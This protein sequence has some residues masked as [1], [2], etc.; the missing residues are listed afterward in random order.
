MNQPGLKT[1]F[2][3]W[4]LN[5]LAVLAASQIVSGITYDSW[6]SLLIASLVLGI[7]NAFLRPLLMLF[8]VV[9]LLLTLG[10]FTLVINALL[11]YLVSWLV[12]GFHV[13]S[14]GAAFWGAL[15]ISLVSWVIGPW[16]GVEK[17]QRGKIEMRVNRGKRP[18]RRDDGPGGPVIDV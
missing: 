18:P 2:L 8:S 10:L 7:L 13:A 1:F 9:L 5:T 15:V 17:N 3:R 14:F 16:L 6:T 12:K 11:L 4:L